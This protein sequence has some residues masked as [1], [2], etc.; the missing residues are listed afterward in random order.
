MQ[1]N[2]DPH[3]TRRAILQAAFDRIHDKGFQAAGLAEI[4]ADTGFTK[5][6]LYHHF[7]NKMALG[8]AVVDELLKDYVES[9]WL[10]P[11]EDAEDPLDGLA[12]L[13]QQ[14]LSSGIPG[15]V[16]LGCPLNNL[17]QEMPAVDEGFRQRLEN[18][19]RMWRKG[20]ARALRH[21]QQNGTVRGDI[22][23]EEA[24]AFIIAALEGAFGQAKTAQSTE[25]FQE[26]MG[27]L[28]RYLTSLR[29]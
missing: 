13:I 15:M 9:W 14:R 1:R 12:R 8:Y 23:A 10:T 4:L 3:G 20:L 27:G 7:P 29:P 5:G 21:G 6:A 2:R 16:R 25:A 22:H 26:C 17:A 28:S 19:Y 11:L 18:L 24:A